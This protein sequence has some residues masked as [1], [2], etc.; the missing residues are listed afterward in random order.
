MELIKR[1]PACGDEN[2]ASEVV[3][4]VCMADISSIAPVPEGE[5][6]KDP[7]S[8]E[9]PLDSGD[10]TMRSPDVL[11]LHR[12]SDGRAVPVTS[13]SVIGRSGDSGKFFS[14]MRTVSRQHARAI[15]ADGAWSIED[16]GSTN[17]TWLNGRRMEPGRAYPL[18]KG[19]TLSLSL[20]CEMRVVS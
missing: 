11:T 20:A 9:V 8:E 1:C 16:L 2:P 19:D 3:C 7:P 13:G 18:K 15:F 6:E 14:D 4:R 5:P 12:I 10:R 17:G